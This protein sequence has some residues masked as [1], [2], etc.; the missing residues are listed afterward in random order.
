MPLGPFGAGKLGVVLPSYARSYLVVAYRYLIG[1]PLDP[2]EQQAALALWS[3]RLNPSWS[4]PNSPDN[5]AL[6]TWRAA[7][8][9]VLGAS[10]AP[11]LQMEKE[12]PGSTYYVTY[13]NCLP[14]A[15]RAAAQTLFQRITRFGPANP[16][17]RDWL[18]AQDAVFV[19]CSDGAAIPRAGCC[20]C[21]S[22]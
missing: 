14:N 4:D 1:I 22:N 11:D 12:I 8:Q 10:P 9:S 5:V 15:F 19:N 2:A 21:V 20:T 3:A 7:R 6:D 13:E 16:Q 17:V 18:K